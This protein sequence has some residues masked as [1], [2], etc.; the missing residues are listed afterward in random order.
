MPLDE[1]VESDGSARGACEFL[2][3]AIVLHVEGLEEVGHAAFHFDGRDVAPQCGELI[4]FDDFDM[5]AEGGALQ[6]EV[7][8]DVEHAAVIVAHDAEAVVLHRMGDLGGSEPLLDFVPRRGVVFQHAG[9]LEEGDIA[10]AEYVGDFGYGAGLAPCQ[11]FSGHLSAIRHSIEGGVVD[12]GAGGEIEDD[13]G[14]FRA[15][16]DGQNGGRQSVRRDVQKEQI[17]IG[18]SK[19]VA[20]G[21]SLLRAIDHAQIDDLDAGAAEALRD[22]RGIIVEL[23]PEAFELTP[24]GFQADGEESYAQF[25]RGRHGPCLEAKDGAGDRDRT[26][27]QQLGR[28]RLYH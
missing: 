23:L 11:P 4:Y 7:G 9:N 3:G 21:R 26:G 20:G 28:L 5:S 24:I 25:G 8:V 27:D 17:H 2:A 18:A 6:G 22:L 13:H 19:G 1:F 16:H 12:G 15:A 10:A 14:D